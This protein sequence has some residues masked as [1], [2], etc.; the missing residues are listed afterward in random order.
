MP[1]DDSFS[2]FVADQLEGMEGLAIKRMFGGSGLYLKQNFFGIL[3]QGKLYFKTN[4]E[5]LPR[6]TTH[7]S[8]PFAYSKKGKKTIRLK[9]YYEV[10]VDVLEDGKALKA[11]ALQ[12]AGVPKGTGA[13]LWLK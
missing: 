9:N 8:K 7:N 10:P 5:T 3:S 2:E 4:P 13:S 12:A 6:Y 1:K 11:W